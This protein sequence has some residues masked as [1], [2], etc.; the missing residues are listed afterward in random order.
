MS[1]DVPKTPAAMWDELHRMF[2]LGSYD[3]IAASEPWYRE[4]IIEIAKLK[5]LLSSRRATLREVWIAA[6]YA[7]RENRPVHSTWHVFALIPEAM[8]DHFR[9]ATDAKRGDAAEELNTAINE[10][11]EA[12]D[13]SWAQRLMRAQD[14][15]S[16]LAAWKAR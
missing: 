14:P 2:G 15:E 10:A 7:R 11:L 13:N 16:V 12:G 6:Q 1:D 9:A 4:R 5:R 8:R 3:D